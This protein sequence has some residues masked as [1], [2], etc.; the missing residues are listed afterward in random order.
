MRIITGIT[1]ASGSIYAVSLVKELVRAGSD[2]HLIFSDN[3]AAVMRHE[4]GF[5][6]EGLKAALSEDAGG[7]PVHIHDNGDLFAAPASGSF[8]ADAMVIVPCSMATL[9]GIAS[10]NLHSLMGRSADVCL[11]EGRKLVAVPRETPLS[12]IHL[13]NMLSLSEAGAV[14]LPAMP[15]FYS[16]PE[17]IEELINF[18]TARILDQLGIENSL[19][20]RWREP[21]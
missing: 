20:P 15:G 7:H 13:K 4:T 9:G 18:V 8:R 21:I 12:R 11:K 3:G 17:S 2:V 6:P 16:R 19:S 1:G 5:E 10:G 14:I